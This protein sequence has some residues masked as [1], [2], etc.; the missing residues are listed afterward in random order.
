M[1]AIANKFRQGKSS[2]LRKDN[3]GLQ[4]SGVAAWGESTFP[5]EAKMRCLI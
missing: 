3:G 5:K 2:A 1:P 4:G